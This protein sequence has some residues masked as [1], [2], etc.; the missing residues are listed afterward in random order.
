MQSRGS[1]VVSALYQ[2]QGSQTCAAVRM[3]P[4]AAR[5]TRMQIGLSKSCYIAIAMHLL[6]CTIPT[7][8]KEQTVVF[9]MRPRKTGHIMPMFTGKIQHDKKVP[10]FSRFSNVSTFRAVLDCQLWSL[11]ACVG[12][13]ESAPEH[14]FWILLLQ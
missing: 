10:T 11:S 3:K 6:L 13:A 4:N 8:A 5:M 14:R 1:W 12:I 2:Q 9:A 7:C